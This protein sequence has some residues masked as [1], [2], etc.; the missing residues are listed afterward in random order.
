M[1][2]VSVFK[3]HHLQLKIH[4]VWIGGFFFPAIDSM[5]TEECWTCEFLDHASTMVPINDKPHDLGRWVKSGER[6][7]HIPIPEHEVLVII[8]KGRPTQDD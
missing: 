4:N 8:Q 6:V 1:K 5:E 3:L 7:Y 2:N